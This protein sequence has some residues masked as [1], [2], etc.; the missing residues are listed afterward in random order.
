MESSGDLGS[1]RKVF[2]EV[3]GGLG[4]G[5]RSG[6]DSRMLSGSGGQLLHDFADSNAAGDARCVTLL[7]VVTRSAP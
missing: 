1:S 2:S 5:V 4:F 7:H 3:S 6:N